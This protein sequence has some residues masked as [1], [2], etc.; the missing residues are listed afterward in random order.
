LIDAAVWRF[1]EIILNWEISFALKVEI[2]LLEV[3]GSKVGVVVR[4]FD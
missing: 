4:P 3:T 2:S 1:L